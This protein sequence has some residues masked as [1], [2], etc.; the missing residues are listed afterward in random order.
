M[1]VLIVPAAKSEITK[2]VCPD[3]GQKVQNVGL[4]KESKIV[5]LTFKCKKCGKLWEV[6][7]K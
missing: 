7:T 5:G 1:P 2:I 6:T 3:C 4:V